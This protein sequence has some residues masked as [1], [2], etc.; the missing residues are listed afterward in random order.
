MAVN[1]YIENN[2]VVDEDEK[3]IINFGLSIM[4]TTIISLIVTI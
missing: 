1:K 2:T 3:E 4:I